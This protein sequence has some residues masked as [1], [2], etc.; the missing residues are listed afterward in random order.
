MP[1]KKRANV[2]MNPAMNCPVKGYVT[3]VHPYKNP[4]AMTVRIMSK[5]FIAGR[6]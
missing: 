1:I 2:P 6:L 5:F 4:L 3:I